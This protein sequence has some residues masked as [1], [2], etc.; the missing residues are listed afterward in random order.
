M[1]DTGYNLI[2]QFYYKF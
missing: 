1:R 2:A